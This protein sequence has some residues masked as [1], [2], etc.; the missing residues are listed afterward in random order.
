M[1]VNF[2][3]LLSLHQTNNN[4]FL[5]FNYIQKLIIRNFS[6]FINSH[7]NMFTDLPMY[8]I[9]FYKR[10]YSLTTINHCRLINQQ[11]RITT[12]KETL[13]VVITKSNFIAKQFVTD[14][15]KRLNIKMRNLLTLLWLVTIKYYW[16]IIWWVKLLEYIIH[17]LLDT[18]AWCK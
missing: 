8:L 7:I 12:K 6:S 9:D 5:F 13:H 3:I 4:K 15:H 10:I 11:L 14:L 17:M 16:L 1:T 2:E 18:K